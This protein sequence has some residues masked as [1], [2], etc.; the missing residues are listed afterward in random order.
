VSPTRERGGARSA[1]PSEQVWLAVETS[2]PAGSVAV[3]NNGFAFEQTLR[4]HGTHSERLVPAIEHAL[5]ATEIR[6][7]QVTAFVVG[8]GPGSFTGVR[9]GASLAKGWAMARQTPLFAYSSLLAVAAG[10]GATGPVCAL[11]DARRG[12]V[13]AACYEVSAAG[14]TERLSPAACRIED[15]LAELSARGLEPVFAGDGAEV[16][17]GAIRAA[18][19]EALILPEHLGLP[20][21]ASLLW[22]RSVAADLGRVD[23]PD[24]WEPIYVRDWK[25]SEDQGRR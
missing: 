11:F 1:D 3:W 17:R 18:R 8:S 25:I 23:H 15:L 9:I 14:V 10:C 12:E 16:H 20:R 5:A 6:P 19:A 22:L 2:T 7:E 24:T 13:Y 21:A 4:I